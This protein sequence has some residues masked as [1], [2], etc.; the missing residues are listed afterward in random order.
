MKKVASK[1]AEPTRDADLKKKFIKRL[2]EYLVKDQARKS[3]QLE[4]GGPDAKEWASL[5][6]LTPIK[7]YPTV[8]EA[9]QVL[10]QKDA[11]QTPAFRP[12]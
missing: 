9:E 12:E 3:I 2:A 11:A 8:E 5:R 6:S 4:M 7:G 1:K 10:I